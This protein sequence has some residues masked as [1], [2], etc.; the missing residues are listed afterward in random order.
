VKTSA[1]IVAA[2]SGSRFQSE[3]PKQF[4]ELAETRRRARDRSL[5]SASSIDSIVVVLAEDR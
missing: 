5:S 1:I 2:G 3:T 4:L